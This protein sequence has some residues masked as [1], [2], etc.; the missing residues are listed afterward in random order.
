MDAKQLAAVG[1]AIII[2]SAVAM[3]ALAGGRWNADSILQFW[4]FL[5][6]E[7]I[8]FPLLIA[9]FVAMKRRQEKALKPVSNIAI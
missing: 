4:L 3:M 2:I 6:L 1:I 7:I 5:L 9:V 8:F